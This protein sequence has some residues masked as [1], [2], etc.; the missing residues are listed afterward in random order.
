[1]V[2]MGRWGNSNTRQPLAP[3]APTHTAV[4]NPWPMRPAGEGEDDDDDDNEEEEDPGGKQPKKDVRPVGSARG[5]NMRT[6]PRASVPVA[7]TKAGEMCRIAPR[8]ACSGGYDAVGTDV[9]G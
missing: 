1:M 7:T 8:D 4:E 3:Y 6:C 2:G 9:T 5:W